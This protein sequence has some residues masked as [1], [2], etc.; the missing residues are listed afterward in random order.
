MKDFL[1]EYGTL[2]GPLV[3]FALGIIALLIKFY[4]DRKLEVWKSNKKIDKLI[5]L[6]KD[7]QPP[8]RY[9]P[10]KGDGS[11]PHAHEARN[12]TNVSMY[13]KKIKVIESFINKIEDDVLTNCS[14]LKV[15]Q[16]T[17]LK[18]IVQYLKRDIEEMKI[19][20][21]DGK[22]PNITI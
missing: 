16:V 20:D 18:F 2:I 14:N 5:S 17:D 9:W 6:I 21:V 13:S 7:S 12:L 19:S 8:N 4:I 1:K 22:F 15:Q 10:E 3:A 11:F